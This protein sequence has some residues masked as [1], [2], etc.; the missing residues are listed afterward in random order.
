MF[1]G[2]F[3]T[4]LRTYAA[5][6]AG[7]NLMSWRRFLAYN[8]AGGILWAA[9]VGTGAYLLGAAAHQV[10]TVVTIAGCV[11]VVAVIA[12][13]MVYGRRHMQRLERKAEQ[14]YPGPLDDASSASGTR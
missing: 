3:V 6:L 2:R 13:V 10:G 1:V 5:F 12:A 11:L 14:A 8:A 7:T 9:L 4:V